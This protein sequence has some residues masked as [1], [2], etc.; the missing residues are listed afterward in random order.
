MI[1]QTLV[2]LVVAM[3]PM[4]AAAHS[5]SEATTPADGASVTDVPELTIRFDDPM[6][7][8]SVAL[9]SHDDDVEIE[10]ETGMDP[11]TE[12]RAMPLEELAPGSYRFD[13]RGMASD[14]H[15]MQG[16]FSFTVAE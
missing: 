5:K 3:A 16:S 2:G 10:R 9:T 11:T 12:F 14:G 8:I 4:L 13:W 15:P 6:R 1:K 7:I